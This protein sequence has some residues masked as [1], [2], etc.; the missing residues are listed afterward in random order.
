MNTTDVFKS[1]PMSSYDTISQPKTNMNNIQGVSLQSIQERVIPRQVST[2]NNRG[3]MTVKGLIRV[4][5]TNS[6]PMIAM[7][8][9][10]GAF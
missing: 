4:V 9:K 8:Y 2:G 10:P 3:E 1:Q 5:D 6:K 7:G